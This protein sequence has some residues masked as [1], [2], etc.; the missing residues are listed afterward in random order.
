[1]KPVDGDKIAKSIR[2]LWREFCDIKE[3]DEEYEYNIGMCGGLLLGLRIVSAAP[4]L[5]P[6]YGYWINEH[7]D[8]HGS[9][10]GTCSECGKENHVDNFCPYCGADMRGTED[11]RVHKER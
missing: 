10:V 8:G 11:E 7:E 4:I 3:D 2:N 1:M 9:W 6:K 5:W